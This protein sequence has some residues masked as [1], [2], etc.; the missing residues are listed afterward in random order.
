MSDI[1]FDIMRK[2]AIEADLAKKGSELDEAMRV[3][4]AQHERGEITSEQLSEIRKNISNT[5]KNKRAKEKIEEEDRKRLDTPKKDDI[6]K[7]VVKLA[8]GTEVNDHNEL[9]VN[10][11]PL[12]N[13]LRHDATVASIKKGG[14]D[15]NFW[16]LEEDDAIG[17]LREKYSHTDL[18]FEKTEISAVTPSYDERKAYEESGGKQGRKHVRRSQDAVKITASDGSFEIIELDIK[19]FFEPEE[20][21]DAVKID[22]YNKLT[23]FL[24]AHTAESDKA[25]TIT[26]D[27]ERAIYLEK[28]RTEKLEPTEEEYTAQIEEKELTSTDIFNEKKDTK[29]MGGAVVE[30]NLEFG[31]YEKEIGEARKQLIQENRNKA[32]AS[33]TPYVDPT[34]DEIK[35]KALLNLQNAERKYLRTDK[36]D[37]YMNELEDFEDW[38]ADW[39]LKR[40]EEEGAEKIGTSFSGKPI[41]D[42][43]FKEKIRKEMKNQYYKLKVA[44]NDEEA[45]A[46]LK[47]RANELLL[48]NSVSNIEA[49]DAY[50]RFNETNANI[51]NLKHNY[52][53]S[54]NDIQL[55]NGKVIPMHVWEQHVKDQAEVQEMMGGFD[56]IMK[57]ADESISVLEDNSFKWD[58]IKRNYNDW[59][60]TQEVLGY[61][62]GNLG[63][64][65]V[66]GVPKFLTFGA[67]GG[68]DEIIRWKEMVAKNRQ[69]FRK[70]VEWDRAFE[71]GNFGRFMAQSAVDQIPIYATLATGNLGLGVLGASVYGDKWAEMTME[72]RYKDGAPSPTWEKWFKSLG[73]A[74]SE[75][76][77]DYAITVPIMRNARNMMRGGKGKAMLDNSM[78]AFFKENASKALVFSPALEGISEGA[79]QLTQ[80]AIDG[81]PITEGLDHAAFLGLTMG[82]GMSYT[83]FTG[84]LI[85][86]QFSD[87]KSLQEVR[88]N[89]TEMQKLYDINADI[90]EGL[91]HLGPRSADSA[92]G[93]ETIKNNE[94]RIQELINQNDNIINKVNNNIKEKISPKA[95]REFLANELRSEQI[96]VEAQ[97]ILD[98][99]LDKKTQDKRLKELL[100]YFDASNSAA[101]HF[102]DPKAFGSRWTFIT[103]ATSKEGKE[104]LERLK[105]LARTELQNEGKQEPDDKKVL[106]RARYVWAKEQVR[107][108]NKS[109]QR[110]DLAKNYKSF[111]TI[112]E[113]ADAID[114]QIQG[115]I[116]VLNANNK[117]G[118][119]DN[120]I[121]RLEETKK[122]L[123][124]AIKSGDTYGLTHIDI[125]GESMALSV[126]ETQAKA[127]RF[128]TRTHEGGHQVFW[129]ALQSEGADVNFTAMA[130]Q[131]LDWLKK[132]DAA[133]LKRVVS[134]TEKDIDGNLISSEVISVFLEE[135]GSGKFDVKK[136]KGFTNL[137]GLMSN[138]VITKTTGK[139]FEFDFAGETDV[140][141]FLIGLGKKIKNGTLTKA[142]ERA[143]R[144]SEL[145][146]SFQTKEGVE[147]ITTQF[148]K[149]ASD[150]VQR[151]YEEQGEAGAFEIIEEFKPITTRIARRYRE[152]PG[153]NEELLVSEIEIGKRGIFDLIKEYN[154]ESGV[155]LAAYINKYL[156][157]RSIEAANRI[158]EEQF[159]EDVSERVDVAAEEVADVDVKAR[160]KKKKIILSDR[161]GV[162]SKVDKAIKA[163][164]PEL[165][166]ENL[167]FKTLKD[168]T[169][170]ITG[171]MFGISPKKLIS[172]A[173]IT[174]K[175]LQSAQ[176]FINKNADVL[177]SMLPEGAT[178]GGTATGVPQTLLK[179]FY[180]K[181]D[182]AKMAKTGTKAGLAV[183]VKNDIKKVDFLETFGIIDGKP[184]RT[185]RNTSARVLALANQTG[186]MM[187]NQAVRQEVEKQGNVNQS[188]VLKLQDGKSSVMFSKAIPESKHDIYYAKY[189]DLVVEISN[190]NNKDLESIKNRVTNTFKD[191]FTKNEIL[192]VSKEIFKNIEE[193]GVLE[194]KHIMPSG[195]KVIMPQTLQEFLIDK[196]IGDNL[197]YGVKEMLKKYLPKDENGKTINIGTHYLDKNRILKHRALPVDL[198][199]QIV[200]EMGLEKGVE[201]ILKY[202]QGMFSGLSRIA[203][204][205]YIFKDGALI[206]NPNYEPLVEK[207]DKDGVVKMVPPK[208]RKQVFQSVPDFV[209]NVIGKLGVNVYNN[210]GSVKTVNQIQK[211]L[212]INTRL[213]AEKSEAALRDMDF[214]GR[215]TQANEAKKAVIKMMDFVTKTEGY[216]SVD[217][218]MLI[219]S[220]G[221]G[222]TSVMRRAA[223]F[224][225][226]G[227]GVENS[228]NPG[229]ELEYEHMIPQVEMSLKILKSYLENGSVDNSIWE[230]YHVAIIPKTMDDVL[231]ENKFRSKSPVS[232][233]RYYNMVNFGDKRL[234]PIKSID[235]ADN[236]KI[237]G[238]D[239]VKAG[240]IINGTIKEIQDMGVVS[241][242]YM[243][244]RAVNPAKGITVL[245][246]DDTLATSKSLV[247]ST[248]PE[249]TVRKLTAEEFAQ[250]G[251]DLLDQG[252]THDFSEFSKVVDGKVASLFNKAMKLQSKFGP[253]NMFVLTARPADSADAIHVFLTANGLNIPLKNITGLANSTPESKALWIADKVAEGYNDFYFADDALQNVQAVQN[254]LDQFDVKSKV[255]QA[256]VQFSRDASQTFNDILESTT[257]VESI[258]EFSDAQARLR[259]Q[260]TKY[261]SIIPASAQDFQGL[262]YS[263]LGKGKKGEADMAFFKKALIDPFARGINELNSSRQSAANDFENLN[264]KFPDVK[265]KLN[266]GIEGLDY[267]NDQAMRVY[268]WNKAGFEVPGLSKRDLVA[269]TSFVE[270]NP[271]MKAYADVIGLISKKEDGY[272]KPKD[273]WLAENITSD[274]LSD[275][276][277]GD[278]RSDFLAEWIQNKDMIFSKENLNKIEAIY[279]SKFREALEDMLYRM[280][281]GRNRPTGNSRLVNGYM[282][283]VNN[284]VGAI[285]FLNLR[286]ATLQTISATNY[287]N[288]TDNNPLK[289][290]MAFANQKQFWSD[291]SMI[292]NS[293]YLKQRRA[294]N[295]R[296]I[297]EA[298][299]SAAIA[300]S[301]NK[302]KAA[303]AWLLKKGFTPTQIADSF[304]I[305]IGGASMLRNR[306]KTY[307]KDGMS[308]KD[309]EAKAWLDF[310]EIT[311]TNQQSA[312]P[313]MISQQQASPLGRLI[314]AFQNT[315][316][317]YARIMNKATRDLANGRGDYKAHISKIAYYGVV[318]S[319]IF[320][321]LQSALYASLG[322]D[323]EE[324]FDKK[325]ERILNQMVD[326][327]L[328]GIGVGGKAVST[329]KN[330]LMEYFKQRDKGFN[331]DHAYTLLTILS[332]SPPIGSKLRKIYSSIQTEEF[333][334]GVFSKRGFTLDNPIW[335][336][337]GNVV[338]GVTN[339]PLGRMSNLML[340]LDNAMDPAHKWWQRVALLL[341]QNTWDLGIKDPDIEAAKAD[342]KKDK[343]NKK[344]T[345][346]DINKE[347]VNKKKQAQER[348]EGKTV[349]CA[350]VSKSGNRCKTKVEPGSSYCTV[351]VK[352]KQNKDGKKSQCR[353]I[354]KGGKRCKMQT[355]ASSGYCYYHD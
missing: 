14:D 264:K 333:N 64:T 142:D 349:M 32:A 211:D 227:I 166:I 171:E 335:S 61:G 88:D 248:S 122:E 123:I 317:Q 168:Q 262:L 131:V 318:Q 219:T 310:Q 314:L 118:T 242:A 83:G 238:E 268:L 266:E 99:G 199:K 145:L 334:R 112:D 235:P 157:A 323:D 55:E 224:K 338:E 147:S 47:Y 106:E 102:K 180:T 196:A 258:K 253:E 24:E 245:D 68:D 308:Q 270:N 191:D 331:S 322:D 141:N 184:D 128:E 176:M 127:E 190:S 49:S 326:S 290:G 249:G 209:E 346:K 289:A 74:A 134:L 187:T 295:Q 113:A 2:S 297:N 158:L 260:K 7:P 355:S 336:G 246:F 221:S 57:Q 95:Y 130:E 329:V 327:W 59:E 172:G 56:S 301:D 351:H 208:N 143:I 169:P 214:T 27:K 97:K 237:I 138:D 144:K 70:D 325:K 119:F 285:M 223:N 313:D 29:Q 36:Y 284:S 140:M 213:L 93:R 239:F 153:Y 304:A 195:R 42:I 174:K 181:T 41:W 282:N 37:A 207:T 31:G 58:M 236:G 188:I 30:V 107:E 163:K 165:D 257:G 100:V 316:M 4:V 103:N 78:P 272:S 139:D 205:R 342:V 108:S 324:N 303:I 344:K 294:G 110:T 62:F 111:E 152:V 60:R 94:A 8:D 291:F 197:D 167:N 273:Y 101:Q 350:A 6:E 86:S 15:S 274:L 38:D 348:K 160:P 353:K 256:K 96:K 234:V 185:D 17:H 89:M 149:E 332:F 164:L 230:G 220:M 320:G 183:Q 65:A 328:T 200:E 75:V 218:G 91:K 69:S 63:M 92:K 125:F 48:K 254:M 203:D 129:N 193:Y 161:L 354:K 159:T 154:L 13:S 263:F 90:T 252:W 45:N 330:T 341:G 76:V 293:P 311:E 302:A 84:G 35:D 265:K 173:N 210:D 280:E 3:H 178:A 259:G 155:P 206:N 233:N 194:K 137:W 309:A 71:D 120:H 267:T 121:K 345:T 244:S 20:G 12:Y 11:N 228:K 40:A 51:Q 126:V 44:G 216:D 80:N 9:Y 198:G 226:M 292:W 10:K 232:G 352:V 247:I 109:Y 116:N 16:E 231:V 117:D 279:G 229:K 343:K 81:R 319:I 73:Y 312:R 148:S 87:H 150:N 283:W 66:Y 275:G 250:E 271:E 34:I 177:I 114:R 179:A 243:F 339:I 298:E 156:P 296:G 18:E 151:V 201:F 135:V 98:S 52:P 340:Q 299:L 212:G 46:V 241:R 39:I 277:I 225:Y 217:V 1:K 287:I 146:R 33:N 182:R 22:N 192:K 28:V 306:I 162:K 255:Q 26:N 261:K 240:N 5:L 23:S 72:D 67:S 202:Y 315:P 79:T 133:M 347:A 307:V 82:V 288:W 21:W 286:S 43:K 175:E 115:E 204:G 276:A 278:K 269:L 124:A 77:L 136:N 53:S 170:E 25:Q 281:T 337:I 215:E 132:N 54:D 251:A 321:A 19:G 186:K 222:M 85:T 300:G 189:G 305:S 50:K 104:N 105:D